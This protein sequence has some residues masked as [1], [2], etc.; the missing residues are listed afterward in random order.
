MLQP[1]SHGLDIKSNFSSSPTNN[2]YQKP[3]NM[4]F[5]NNLMSVKESP[6]AVYLRTPSESIKSILSPNLKTVRSGYE[7]SSKMKADQFLFEERILLRQN[8]DHL[9]GENHDSD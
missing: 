8:D 1:E 5:G 4:I 9:E 3:Q 6:K 7:Y 2:L